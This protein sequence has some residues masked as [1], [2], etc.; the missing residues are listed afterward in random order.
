MSIPLPLDSES[1][2]YES[3]VLDGKPAV[4]SVAGNPDLT[5]Q[6]TP[7]SIYRDVFSVGVG[8]LGANA[9]EC[10][11]LS[12]EFVG[13]A[14]GAAFMPTDGTATPDYMLSTAVGLVP[15]I[16]AWHAITFR[17]APGYQLRLEANTPEAGVGLSDIVRTCASLAGAQTVGIVMA[18]TSPVSYARACDVRR[19]TAAWRSTF[20][21]CASGCRSR[22]SANLRDSARSWSAL[23]RLRRRR[24]SRLFFARSATS[25]T[26]TSMPW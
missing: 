9:D 24:R 21:P 20:P 25:T 7:I 13:A 3:R 14:G 18:A 1:A 26:A 15:T 16:Q 8:A 23:P 19:A 11:E 5:A 10:G 22:R 12:G 2:S 17:G 4:C 6:G